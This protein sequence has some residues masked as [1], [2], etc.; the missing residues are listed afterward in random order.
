MSNYKLPPIASRI[1]FL[2][3]A[4]QFIHNPIPIIDSTLKLLGTTYT[5]Y[6]GGVE[7]GVLT[8]DPVAVKHVLQKNHRGYEKSAIV[9][10][11]L[12]KYTGRGLLTSTGDYWLRQRRLIQP[13]FHKRRIEALQ[14]L[15]KS[16]V[17]TCM[18]RWADFATSTTMFD[19]YAEMNHLTFRIVARTLFTTSLEENGLLQLSDLISTLQS[20][21]VKEVRQ[22]YKRWWFNL[23]GS[24]KHHM[25][26]AAGARDIIRQVIIERRKYNEH[27]DDLLSMLLDSKYEDTGLGM[28]DEQLI[29]ECLI[30]FVAGHET[31]ANALSWMIY[32]L[33]KHPEHAQQI[34]AADPVAREIMVRNVIQES[35]RLYPPA[36]VVDRISLADDHVLDYHLPKG[37]VW[38]IYIRGMHRHP[39]YWDQP[40]QFIPDRWN[41]QH[42]NK[43]A[44]MPFG[45]GPRL[46][47]GEHF[48]QM[49]ME[50]ILGEI[51]HL[52][53]I[54]LVNKVITEK[55]LVTLRPLEP[56]LISLRSL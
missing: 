14:S 6:M 48:A 52:W 37:T 3:R 41:D 49:E 4:R 53:D 15:M 13:G 19:A 38:I 45:A 55:P 56:V 27:P 36:W 10:D 1:K 30:L 40:D 47:I 9:T 50:L 21:I 42:L 34:R 31:S 46:C 39:D 23:S 43:E 35:I 25:D 7:K 44:Y 5:F 24:I 17:D 2:L 18:E 54:R 33:G 29:D 22:P 12:A 28:D 20:F 51:I 32:L 11:L 26:L 8:I 16:E